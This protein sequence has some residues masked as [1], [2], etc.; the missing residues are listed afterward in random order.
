[1]A[2]K[3]GRPSAALIEALLADG[4][5]HSFFQALRLLERDAADRDTFLKQVQVRPEL[6]LDYPGSEVVSVERGDEASY[7]VLVSF[8]GL[9]G[10][11]SPLPIFY[12]ED[13]M[14][15]EQDD[16]TAARHLLDI[17]HRRIYLLAYETAKKY[18]PLY[19]VVEDDSQ[20]LRGLLFSLVGLRDRALHEA[21]K[22]TPRLLRY[23]GLFGQQPRSALG[24]KTLLEDAFPGV[25]ADIDQCVARTSLIPQ[26][27]HFMLGAHNHCL[28]EDTV[29]GQQVLDYNARFTVRLGPLSAERFNALQN[30]P[31]QSSLLKF[32]VSRYINGDRK[33]VV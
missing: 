4:G 27:Q 7:R 16:R 3:A 33:N 25:N 17:L 10:V 19:R 23:V 6:S 18:R 26:S 22:H 24:L 11:S 30:D 1:M 5:G 29:V 21:S 20:D 32:L 14:E 8:L 2:S 28:G 9:Y 15:A 12:T 13:L 31:E